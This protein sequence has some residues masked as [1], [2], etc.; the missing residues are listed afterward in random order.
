MTR[1]GLA[2]IPTRINLAL[3]GVVLVL[4]AGALIVVPA[5]GFAATWM[6]Y[7]FAATAAML[8]PMHWALI[9]DGIHGLLLPDR[10]ANER[11]ARMLAILF[12]VSFRAVRFAHFRHHRYNRTPWGREEVY[13]PA[14]RSRP[15]AYVLHY[16][17]ITF[18]LYVGELTLSFVCW[19]PRSVLHRRLHALCPD[20]RDGAP[21]MAAVIDRDVLGASSLV[22]I[23]FDAACS[24]ALYGSAFAI[25]ADRWPVL[26]A[27]LAVRAFISSQLDHAPHHD[28]PLDRRDHALNLSAPRWLRWS[29][30]NFNLHR[31]HH[32]R[33]N[34][35]W[36]ALPEFTTFETGDVSFVRGVLRQWR[37][38]IALPDAG[39]SPREST[40]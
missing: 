35:P 29:L 40:S 3:A 19:L 8:T 1:S 22:Q 9:H 18:G 31:T 24:I 27:M 15:L 30:L 2:R 23:R 26:V 12:G 13:D 11:L 17:R 4:H 20:P 38:P 25:Y 32:Q 7:A 36:R 10:V 6:L 28:T 14:T 39:T 33:P 21:G 5:M 34:L 37:G 16:L